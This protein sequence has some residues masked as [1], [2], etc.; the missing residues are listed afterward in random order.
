MPSSEYRRT[1]S[2]SFAI[3]FWNTSIDKYKMEKKLMHFKNLSQY[4]RR[5][6]DM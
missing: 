3:K 2:Y 6:E 1:F 4:K 5:D